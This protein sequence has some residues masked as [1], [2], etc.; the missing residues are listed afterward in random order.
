MKNK[1]ECP[2]CDGT[3][4]LKYEDREMTFKKEP[5]AV[6]AHYYQCGKCKEEFT[7]TET[8]TLTIAQVQN[9]Y[10]EKHGILFPDEI[11]RIRTTY[12]LSAAGMSDVLGL[13][14]NGYNLYERGEMPTM[15]ISNLI[16]SSN[17]PWAFKEMLMNARDTMSEN[18]FKRTMA[19]VEEQIE[20]KSNPLPFFNKIDLQTKPSALTGYRAPNVEKVKALF[21]TFIS[22]CNTVYNDRLKINKLMFY[23][24]FY[25][26]RETGF[27]ISGLS[28]RAINYG[29]VPTCYDNLF[30]LLESEGVIF[31]DW[32]QVNG[33]SAREIFFVAQPADPAVMYSSEVAVADR[34][35]VQFGDTTSWDLVQM[36]H[37]EDAWQQ[38]N[39]KREIIN[40]Q[41][42]AFDVK[43]IEKDS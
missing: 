8:D 10:R 42:Y 17:N 39:E 32:Q 38:L 7:T 43:G 27:S 34:L 20:R 14:V 25:H 12:G 30:A 4:T 35:C 3:A 11:A 6:K 36:S 19:F 5:F 21:T 13:G 18:I 9:M 31:A 1:T 41:E 23:A 28:Y 40:Y 33:T 22:R 2:Y 15:A 24:D 26:Y 37:R 29:P 16:A